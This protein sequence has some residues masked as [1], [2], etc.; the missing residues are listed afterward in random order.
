VVNDDGTLGTGTVHMQEVPLITLVTPNSLVFTQ[1]HISADMEV[2]E[3]TNAKGLTIKKSHTD[4]NANAK[5]KYS[6]FGGFGASGSTAFNTSSD[7]LSENTSDASDKA[8]GKLHMEAT[9]EPRTIP[10]PQ[11]IIVQKGP[12]L[13]LSMMDRKDLNA[14]GTPEADPAKVT[15]REVTIQAVLVG[16]SGAPLSKKL[17]VT[18]EGS[19]PFTVSNAGTT[20]ATT[21]EL[22]ITVRRGGITKDTVGLVQTNVRASMG[23]VNAGLQ[24]GI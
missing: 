7:G 6:M 5:A 12:K 24:F 2:S 15:T 19:Y 14:A 3:F 1:V 17:T 8:A 16:T 21:G 9:I 22:T 20:D 18:C 10:I 11:P 13:Q 23:L 4:F